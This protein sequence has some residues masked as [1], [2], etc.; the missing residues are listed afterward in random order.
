MSNNNALIERLFEKLTGGDRRGANEVIDEQIAGGAAPETIIA[1]LLWPT[2]ELIDRLYRADELTTLSRNMAIRLLRVIADC[3]GAALERVDRASG[4][5]VLAF[6]GPEETEDLGA[7]MG[8]DLLIASGFDVRFVGG[9]IANDELLSAVH[10]L[11][12]DVLLAFCSAP[13]DLPAARVLIDTLH[14]IG[15]CP[16]MQIAVGG[17]VFNR[18]DGLAEEIG[19][20]VWASDPIELVETLILD[21]AQRA[22]ETQRTVGR[23]RRARLAA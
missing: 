20:D 2:Y 9:G 22:P 12:P 23:A 16:E 19:A 7:Q 11:R 13:S 15:A 10:R 4:R 14:E 1:D 18:A 17:G 8:V 5:R 3:R 6:C 21:A